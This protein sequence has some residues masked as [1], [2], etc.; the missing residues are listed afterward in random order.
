MTSKQHR[1]AAAIS[2]QRQHE[3]FANSDTDGFVSQWASGLNSELHTLLADIIDRGNRWE[4]CGLFQGQRR[5]KAKLISTT[6]RHHRSS[7]WL[8]HDD[9][10]DLIKRRGKKFLPCG[11]KSRILKGLG[12]VESRELAPAW[13]SITGGGTGLAGATACR[14]AAFRVG[15]EW[16]SD[17]TRIN[18]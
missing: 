6:F 13:A 8:L 7:C 3:S 12:L 17:S 16:G 1:E 9:E 4:F 14:P 18:D 15:C 5:V 11:K 10:Q 2:L